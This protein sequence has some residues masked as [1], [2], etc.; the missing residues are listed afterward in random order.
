[1]RHVLI[2]CALPQ[3]KAAVLKVLGDE[4]LIKEF[5]TKI[6][7]EALEFIKDKIKIIVVESGMGNVNAGVNLALLLNAYPVEQV[8]L[9]GVGGALHEDLNIGDLILSDQVVQHDY[10][11]SLDSGDYLMKPGELILSAEQ[12][13]EMSPLIISCKSL[14]KLEGLNKKLKN[15]RI[16]KIASG[17]EFV[18]TTKNKKEIY[19]KTDHCVLVDMEASAIA[20][21]A[22]KANIPFVIAKTV[23]DHLNPDGSIETDFVK[24]LE[25][26]ATNAAKVV[27][28]FIDEV[29]N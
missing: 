18:G 4:Y 25:E 6:K 19:A 11:S 21:L 16:A 7:V 8:L 22:S 5:G 14:V 3:E 9:V 23:S 2:V 1:M 10:F 27:E 26:A 13:S 24:F 17:N 15:S 12:A 20:Y 29:A 28:V